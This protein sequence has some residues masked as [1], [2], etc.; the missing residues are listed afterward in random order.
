VNRRRQETTQDEL[1]LCTSQVPLAE[2]V[3]GS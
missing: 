2:R 3:Q 1:D